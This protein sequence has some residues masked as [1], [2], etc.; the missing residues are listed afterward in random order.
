MKWLSHC[1][2]YLRCYGSFVK[3]PLTGKGEIYPP[4]FKNEKGRLEELQAS[5]LHLCSWQDHGADPPGN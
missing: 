1:P 3:F 5:E 2:S 4:F